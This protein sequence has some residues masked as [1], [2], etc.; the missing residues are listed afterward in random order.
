MA[1]TN[2]VVSY[3]EFQNAYKLYNAKSQILE[4]QI[5][6][7]QSIINS[8]SSA[9]DSKASRAY[10]RKL[11]QRL[12]TL[13]KAKERVDKIRDA[14]PVLE[15]LYRTNEETVSHQSEALSDKAIFN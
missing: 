10:L 14:M 12:S 5:N 4:D 6:A 13:K 8:F 2:I 1:N 3:Q 7:L 9:W 11:Q 15:E